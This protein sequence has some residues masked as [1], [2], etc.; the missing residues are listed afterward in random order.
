MKFMNE[1]KV[2][3]HFS[4]NLEQAEEFTIPFACWG[5]QH[6]AIFLREGR[7]E[8]KGDEKVECRHG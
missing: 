2:F 3:V 4:L 7:R 1:E 5:T 8:Q 6:E